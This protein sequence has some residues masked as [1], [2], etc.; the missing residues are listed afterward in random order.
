MYDNYNY[1][2]KKF[3][4]SHNILNSYVH[5]INTS[6]LMILQWLHKLNE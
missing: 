1:V 5:T 2:K 4:Y 6:Y 3:L